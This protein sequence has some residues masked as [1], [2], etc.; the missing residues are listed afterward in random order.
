MKK[1]FNSIIVFLLSIL[2]VVS[3]CG[4]KKENKEITYED[5]GKMIEIYDNNGNISYYKVSS[6]NTDKLLSREDYYDLNKQLKFYRILQYDDNKRLIQDTYYTKEGFGD[7]Y[8]TYSYY[9]NGKISEKGY[10]PSKGNVVIVKFDEK[11]NYSEKYK[12]NNND[13]LSE[14]YIYRDNKWEKAELPS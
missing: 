11:G 4:C 2:F 7:H 10:Y 5:S 3:I 9:D 1:V 13:I 14:K 6:F 12:Y 8:Y